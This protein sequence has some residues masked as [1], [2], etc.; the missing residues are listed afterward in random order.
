LLLT[1]E[2]GPFEPELDWQG[3]DGLG[4]RSRGR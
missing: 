1:T 4:A 2:A 3:L